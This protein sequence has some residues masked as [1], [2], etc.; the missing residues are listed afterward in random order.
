MSVVRIRRYRWSSQRDSQHNPI[1]LPDGSFGFVL[2]SVVRNRKYRWTSQRDSQLNPIGLPDGSFGFVLIA[3]QAASPLSY[4]TAYDPPF[5]IV[6][7][8]QNRLVPVHQSELLH[9]RNRS[10]P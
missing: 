7:G 1:G 9:N 6:H 10:C 3:V 5:L 2:M 8:D 4:V